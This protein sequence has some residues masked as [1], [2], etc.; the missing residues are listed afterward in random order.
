MSAQHTPGPWSVERHP[1]SGHPLVA[2]EGEYVVAD[3]G[4]GEIE[5][6]SEEANARLIAAAPELLEALISL[7]DFLRGNGTKSARADAAISKA[8]AATEA[9]G[10]TP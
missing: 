6:A 7:R 10:A 1:H 2:G 5:T 4:N 3:C 9:T 8:T